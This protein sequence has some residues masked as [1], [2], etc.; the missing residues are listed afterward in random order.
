MSTAAATAWRVA[1]GGTVTG[2]FTVPGDKSISPRAL[3]LGAIAQGETDIRGF[4]D[5][6]DCLATARALAALKKRASLFR[7]LG[8]YPR[9]VQ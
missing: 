3:M 1:P 6:E 4:L 5:G 8:S 7:V 9:A 2:S